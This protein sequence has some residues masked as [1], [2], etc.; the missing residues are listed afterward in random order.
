MAD[1]KDREKD[2]QVIAD[3]ITR[4]ADTIFGAHSP[5]SG[6]TVSDDFRAKVAEK[7]KTMLYVFDMHHKST[8]IIDEFLKS[9]SE[10]DEYRKD[11]DSNANSLARAIQRIYP[12]LDGELE[13]HVP[14]HLLGVENWTF[15]TVCVHRSDASR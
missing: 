1:E 3:T 11:M 10:S 8:P 2:A 15:W 7:A 6:Q 9:Y 13:N 12:H 14:G 5:E 4:L